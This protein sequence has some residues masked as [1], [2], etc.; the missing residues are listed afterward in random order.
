M[1]KKFG[2]YALGTF[3]FI[4]TLAIPV[5]FIKGAVWASEHL[6]QGLIS[7]GWW[8]LA[9]TILIAL[10]LSIFRRVRGAVAAPT[11]GQWS[12]WIRQRLPH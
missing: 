11:P 6:L 9:A 7:V 5:L 4:A 10:P 12:T 8:V 3:F 1:L 2:F